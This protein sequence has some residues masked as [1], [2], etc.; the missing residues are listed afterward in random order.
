[1][2]GVNEI[3][4]IEITRD[5]LGRE[6]TGFGTPIII[7]DEY[8]GVGRVGSFVDR[9]GVRDAV[10]GGE[11]SKTWKKAN[12]IFSQNP[13]VKRIAIGA[14]ASVKVQTATG[15][16]TQGSLT[17]VVNGVEVV[18]AYSSNLVGTLTALAGAIGSA[19][20]AGVASATYEAN[21][22]TITPTAGNVVSFTISATG[23][24]TANTL[25]FAL[26]ATATAET[27]AQA[28]DAC[29]L[30]ND[31]WYWVLA[32]T[33]ATADIVAISAKIETLVKMYVAQTSEANVVNLSVS[34]DTTSVAS[35]LKATDATRTVLVYADSSASNYDASLV[36]RVA[37]L[38]AGTYTMKFKSF[39]QAVAS[40]LSPTQSVNARDKY[41][42]T[43][44][45]IGAQ[46]ILREGVTPS[47]EFADVIVFVDW[48]KATMSEDVYK[49]LTK[50]DKVPFT[51]NGIQAIANSMEKSLSLGVKRGAI[52][53]KSFNDNDEQDGGYV[54]QVPRKQ[55]TLA[56]DR[57]LRILK[58]VKFTAWIS[59]AV[60]FV[61]INGVVTI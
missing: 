3:V 55:D 5:T 46:D 30:E 50:S 9:N 48:L 59:G 61:E 1:M 49:T 31:Q 7:T 4:S 26:T 54:I 16:M 22:I 8:N 12:A 41:C 11:L 40:S 15:T 18:Q 24:A 53:E 43:Y 33:D 60:H 10:V 58:D 35:L 19:S 36:G 52:S 2:S 28:I 44:E 45:E 23:L 51:D 29:S 37:T 13:R 25:A 6:R 21:A 27:Y 34:S 38:E 42:N 14:K 17:A 32:T 39:A 20:I 57:A 47:G 56:N